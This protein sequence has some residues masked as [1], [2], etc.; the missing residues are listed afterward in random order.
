[1]SE[2][3]SSLSLLQEVKRRLDKK[4]EEWKKKGITPSQEKL[5]KTWRKI[6]TQV[7]KEFY[8]KNERSRKAL[9]RWED[10]KK[11]EKEEAERWK[12]HEQKMKEARKKKEEENKRIKANLRTR[13]KKKDEV[14]QEL[15]EK[16][17][18]MREKTK[19]KL[20]E[21]EQKHELDKLKKVIR[22]ELQKETPVPEEIKAPPPEKKQEVIEK[23]IENE[24]KKIENEVKKVDPESFPVFSIAPKP[25]KKNIQLD[26]MKTY[27]KSIGKALAKGA[28]SAENAL[29]KA[30]TLAVNSALH[31]AKNIAPTVG[32]ALNAAKNLAP[33]GSKVASAAL[34]AASYLVPGG[35]ALRA[36]KHAY[37]VASA[38]ND[39]YQYSQKKKKRHKVK[40]IEKLQEQQK[41][42][43]NKFKN[44]EHMIYMTRQANRKRHVKMPISPI[45]FW[46]NMREFEK[47]VQIQTM[48]QVRDIWDKNLV[49]QIEN[50][51]AEEIKLDA[52][53]KERHSRQNRSIQDAKIERIIEENPELRVPLEK[54]LRERPPSR[55]PISDADFLLSEAKKRQGSYFNKALLY[56]QDAVNYKLQKEHPEVMNVGI[57]P[58]IGKEGIRNALASK[59]NYI[60]LDNPAFLQR[61]DQT[62]NFIRDMGLG[63]LDFASNFIRAAVRYYGN[64][65]RNAG[66]N[67]LTNKLSSV[68]GIA[69]MKDINHAIHDTTDTTEQLRNKKLDKYKNQVTS[70]NRK[71]GEGVRNFLNR[72]GVEGA[73]KLLLQDIILNRWDMTKTPLE[74]LRDI[75][76]LK[77]YVF[78]NI[79]NPSLL[80]DL[81]INSKTLTKMFKETKN[82]TPEAKA[83]REDIAA[84][85]K[86]KTLNTA[87]DVGSMA[88][89]AIAQFFRNG[90]SF[91]TDKLGLKT[92]LDKIIEEYMARPDVALHFRE[93][94]DY[95]DAMAREFALTFLGDPTLKVTELPED[96]PYRKI[97]EAHKGNKEAK[98][99]LAA[100]GL[101]PDKVKRRMKAINE[102]SVLKGLEPHGKDQL[103]NSYMFQT[104][105]NFAE[106]IEKPLSDMKREEKIEN[107]I[108]FT[109]NVISAL[110][111]MKEHMKAI[112]YNTENEFTRHMEKQ[113][114]SYE[115]SLTNLAEDIIKEVDGKAIPRMNGT[116]WLKNPMNSE[117]DRRRN[118][119]V[120]R[121]ASSLLDIGLYTKDNLMNWFRAHK[122]DYQKDGKNFLSIESDLPEDERR[123]LT[124]N[125]IRDYN[126]YVRQE[127]IPLITHHY[128]DNSNNPMLNQPQ[129][130]ITPATLAYLRHEYRQSRPGFKLAKENT[131][132]QKKYKEGSLNYNYLES[133]AVNN[134]ANA[135]METD[136]FSEMLN[137]YENLPHAMMAF[138]KAELSEFTP[139]KLK[140]LNEATI[141][142]NPSQIADYLYRDVKRRRA[143]S[144][145]TVTKRYKP[146]DF[147][148]AKEFRNHYFHENRGN[149]D[150]GNPP[151]HLFAT[152]VAE[153]N[154]NLTPRA[155][156]TQNADI[157]NLHAMTERKFKNISKEEANSFKDFVFSNEGSQLITNFTHTPR[158]RVKNIPSTP[159]RVYNITPMKVSDFA[160]VYSYNESMIN[161]ISAEPMVS[162]FT[163]NIPDRSRFSAY[164]DDDYSDSYLE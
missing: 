71:F 19:E 17:R 52:L 157:R 135:M 26:V 16:N 156:Y 150:D 125:M 7:T 76:E 63:T 58:T 107:T 138:S 39:A 154:Y 34:S 15:K 92:K 77:D 14:I 65:D 94:K 137:R 6:N 30:G 60:M 100:I 23:K 129:G 73:D 36:V 133:Q 134:I 80:D 38:L 13:N 82:T 102:Y 37:N 75:D 101:T 50:K 69:N 10:H 33:S 41:L 120:N 57:A 109:G 142:M 164:A 147:S 132:E 110:S 46:D 116:G 105:E 68:L 29:A 61:G 141:G 152:S 131:E 31:T 79:N 43:E 99:E 62:Y 143:D 146:F 126:H 83:A 162:G 121:L 1:M 87:V 119:A 47:Q 127:D 104:D 67:E 151:S 95:H 64:G 136:Y 114:E 88:L 160:E 149:V 145:D 155:A 42:Y 70:F 85:V 123:K 130:R 72:V 28:G 91:V 40:Y 45:K 111:E 96:N 108:D 48:S 66:I 74:N 11:W 3:T 103:F 24:V 93:T 122:D 139:Q 27:A 128:N 18:A 55:A 117:K 51:K 44:K 59:T 148:G 90:Y 9:K 158:P 12:I 25:P 54:Y 97:F 35:K 53:D 98:E 21:I 5:S 106:A 153:H 78:R 22:K 4:K 81:E 89:D 144:Y 159:P 118:L 113:E 124:D 140:E 84:F 8:E 161:R 112:K 163:V 86:N 115:Q 32:N 56:R 20:K 2:E 49:H